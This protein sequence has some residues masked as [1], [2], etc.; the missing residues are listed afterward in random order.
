MSEKARTLF[1]QLQTEFDEMRYL[2]DISRLRMELSRRLSE[3]LVEAPLQYRVPRVSED[4]TC[5]FGMV[6]NPFEL[7]WAFDLDEKN[8]LRL[9]RLNTALHWLNEM[10]TL[11]W[12][13]IYQKAEEFHQPAYIDDIY[14][15]SSTSPNLIKLCYIGAPSRAAF[16]L[17]ETF[18][19][20]SNNS[21][22]FLSQNP[23]LIQD[24]EK[25]V[26]EGAPYYEC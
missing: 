5:G 7:K 8:R 18:A 1:T 16:P 12:L 20:Q 19:Q 22:S 13:G 26:A 9:N 14:G 15:N 24:V 3:G 23:I 25:A 4:N 2:Q 17:N 10:V 21:R 6:Q 11:D